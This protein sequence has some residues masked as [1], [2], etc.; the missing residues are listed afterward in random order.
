MSQNSKINNLIIIGSNLMQEIHQYTWMYPNGICIEADSNIFSKLKSNMNSMNTKYKEYNIN[1]MAINKLITNED[2]KE[3][4]FNIF[5]NRS[6]SSSI[7]KSNKEKWEWDN[8]KQIN[9]LKC[10]STKMSTLLKDIKW[11]KKRFDV[12]IDVQ[13]A[14]LEV[15]KSFDNYINNINCVQ[16]ESSSKD[17][18]IGQCTV[19]EVHEYLINKKFVLINREKNTINDIKKIGQG[20]LIYARNP[21][22]ISIFKNYQEKISY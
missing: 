12:L 15:I 3:Y 1:Y 10:Y 21:N 7:Y 13:G 5:N 9:T 11:D 8:V 6:G 18:Y 17:Y 19:D 16:V 22:F 4:D 20:D 14:E 2:N